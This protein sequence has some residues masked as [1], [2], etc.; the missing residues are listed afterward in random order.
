M[1]LLIKFL[2]AINSAASPWQIAVAV[3]LGMIVGLTPLLRL[4]N[5]LILFMALFFRIN[6]SSFLVSFLLFSGIAWLFDPLM[7]SAGESVLL[8]PGL[9]AA[10]TA[11]YNT[12]LG[13]LSQFH[14]TLTMGSLLISLVLAPVLLLGT[15]Y[16]VV[17]YRLRIMAWVNKLMIMKFLKASK[18]YRLYAG[19]GN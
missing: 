9:E 1:R 2:K 17:Q 15:Y 8:S 18:L 11:F 16:I 6:F 19:W 5:L 4:H 12:G 10:W 14:H 3:M 7:E 13:Q